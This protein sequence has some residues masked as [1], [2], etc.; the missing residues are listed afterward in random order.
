MPSQHSPLCAGRG[1]KALFLS[2][3]LL[4]QKEI[5][6]GASQIVGVFQIFTTKYKWGRY[7]LYMRSQV[8]AV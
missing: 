7:L 2:A 1:P 6:G 4:V 5:C 3:A 8:E